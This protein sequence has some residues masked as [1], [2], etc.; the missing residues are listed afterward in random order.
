M[1]DVWKGIDPLGAET[2]LRA[3]SRRLN[4]LDIA[5]Q[6]QQELLQQ[7]PA[8]FAFRLACESL[9]NM[10]GN[11]QRERISL[12]K[13]RLYEEIN[14]SIDGDVFAEHTASIG[15]LG[16]LFIRF[17]KLFNSIGQALTTGPTLRG[18]ISHEIRDL[19]DLRVAAF[20]PSSFGMTLI[21]PSKYDLIGESLSASSLA[22]MFQ[23]FNAADE[24]KQI[25]RFS[26]ELGRRAFGHL[27][28]VITILEEQHASIGLK[29]S[30]FTGTKYS[31][32]ADATKVAQIMARLRDIT[33]RRSEDK[34]VSGRLV[35]ASLLKNRFELLLNDGNVIEG[36]M[37]ASAAETVKS[38]FGQICLANITET[39]IFDQMSGEGRSYYTLTHIQASES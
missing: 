27:S 38:V 3:L 16:T 24:E 14:I 39:E 12:V 7:N 34:M 4:E 25:M 31:W 33:E 1:V 29:W 15:V 13:H 22:A 17:Q 5:L 28:H 9:I 2:R 21:T 37:I 30:D 8:S 18:P 26:G 32:S 35:G 6:N 36:K 23:L 19:T 20:Y 10:Q 11:L